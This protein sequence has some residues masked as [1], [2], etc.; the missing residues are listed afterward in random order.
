M[1]S[2]LVTAGPTR[3]YLDDV[4]FLSNGSTGR[5]G[6][7]LCEAALQRGHSAVLV[8]GPVDL[9]PP[10]G[11]EVL[12][13]MSALQMQ[14]EAERAFARCDIAIGAAAV[15]DWR[16]EVRQPGKP[17]RRG[18]RWQLQLVQNPDIIAGLA[19]HKGDR[20]V[21]GF[22]LQAEAAGLEAAIARGADKLRHKQLDLMV[23]NLSSAIGAEASVVVLLFADGHRET[24]PRMDKRATAGHIVDAAVRL[25]EARRRGG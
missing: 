17:P 25:W 5:M 13:V 23:V 8:L 9:P 14:D 19:Q 16:P 15:G 21:V 4:R 18:E 7:A 6:Y 3:E 12:P 10:A 11:I 22:A 24:L 20:V 1:V 2:I